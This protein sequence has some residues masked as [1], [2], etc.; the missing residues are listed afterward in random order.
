MSW[1]LKLISKTNDFFTGI[2]YHKT[3]ETGDVEI[4]I[5]F[6]PGFRIVSLCV[7]FPVIN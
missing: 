1:D 5:L 6:L 4:R 7:F 2:S 3:C